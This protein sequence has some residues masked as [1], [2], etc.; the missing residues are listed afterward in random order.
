M[1]MLLNAI[2]LLC[3]VLIG[4]AAHRASLCNVR[5]VAEVMSTGRAHMLWSLLQ[6]V[7]WMAALTG[8]LVLAFGLA[9]RPTL[10]RT[11]IEWAALGG[12]LF[13]V[14]AA[15]NGGCSLSTLHRLAD[16]D[17]GMLA[18]LAGFVAGV[19]ASL[20]LFPEGALMRLLPES[21]LMRLLPAV[22]PW[23]RWPDLAPWVGGLLFG[24]A[25]WQLR[26]LW[27]RAQHG[28]A[29]PLWRRVL[30]PTYH[31]SVAAALMGLAAGLLYATQ[32]AWS[33][34]NFLR[35]EVLHRAAHTTAPSAW[36]GIL[37]LGLLAGM[38]V[39]ALERGSLAW[40]QPQRLTGWARHAG[41]GALMGLGAALVPGGNDTLL[42]GGLPSLAPA[43]VAA[44]VSMVLG[45]ALMLGLMRLAYVSMPVVTCSPEGCDD[46]PAAL[47]SSGVSS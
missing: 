22:S 14:G 15:V 40:R 7:L 16:G 27:L 23:L 2:A 26:E 18:T 34:S 44:Y 12:V 10:T 45:I 21:A 4:F 47:P 25:L 13:G 38:L 24:W 31:L 33:Y 9:P 32:G 17:L 41:G 11:P 8:L 6:S 30:A 1:V 19:W 39:S 42:L 36:H 20:G 43:A 29:T 46:R 5:A 35:G 37:V 3:V 28:T